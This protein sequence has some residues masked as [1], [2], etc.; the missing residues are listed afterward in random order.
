MLSCYRVVITARARY[1]GI[2]D[3]R[4]A[5]NSRDYLE[6]TSTDWPDCD[7]SPR[8]PATAFLVV[9]NETPGRRTHDHEPVANNGS[10]R[11]VRDDS[12]DELRFY[13]RIEHGEVQR[14]DSN[15]HQ[16]GRGEHC[17]N[18]THWRHYG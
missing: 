11:G 6:K 16:L 17:G 12:R 14:H 10:G 5:H 3:R 4:K 1:C 9:R 15:G 7:S 2:Q 8:I 18:G 13:P